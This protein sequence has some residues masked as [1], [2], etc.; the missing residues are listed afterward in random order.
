VADGTGGE[1]DLP[2]NRVRKI[3]IAGGVVT[4]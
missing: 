2:Y 1:A 4:P 3:V